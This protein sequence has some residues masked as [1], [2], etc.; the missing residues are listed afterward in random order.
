MQLHDMKITSSY[1]ITTNDL[2]TSLSSPLYCTVWPSRVV[3]RALDLRHKRLRLK[4]EFESRPFRF[5]VT[6]FGQ[7]V[8]THVPLSPSS[9]VYSSLQYSQGTVMPCGWGGNRRSGVALAMRH[10][11][12][13]FIQLRTHRLR[14]GDEHP[15]VE[16]GTL[17]VFTVL[18]SFGSSHAPLETD[19]ER[20]PR[21]LRPSTRPRCE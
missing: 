11:L 14:K 15:A 1:Q 12:Q 9:I 6:I 3:V 2:V 16:Y 5:Q 10:R 7:V 18:Q 17:Y 19:T 20:I 4:K 8:H 21:R 13:I